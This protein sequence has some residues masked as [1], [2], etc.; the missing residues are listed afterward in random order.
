MVQLSKKQKGKSRVGQNRRGRG[1]NRI[2]KVGEKKVGWLQ[3]PPQKTK[4]G[5]VNKRN[6]NRGGKYPL[7]PHYGGKGMKRQTTLTRVI[8]RE[9]RK[10]EGGG[11]GSSC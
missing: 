11:R 5:A 7:A 1:K 6:K 3:K 4:S 9:E 2:N 10:K 8:G